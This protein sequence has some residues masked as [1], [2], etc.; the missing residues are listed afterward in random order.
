MEKCFDCGKFILGG[1][2]VCDFIVFV[3]GGWRL[4]TPSEAKFA[5]LESLHEQIFCKECYSRLQDS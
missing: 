1:D 2:L 3:E 5:P 4:S